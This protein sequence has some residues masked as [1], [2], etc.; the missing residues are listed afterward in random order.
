MAST[1]NGTSTGSGGLVSTGDDSGILNIQTNETTAMSIDASQ[2]VDFTNNIDAPNTFGF[3][4]R[5]INGQ[6]QV[7]QYGTSTSVSANASGYSCDRFRCDAPVGQGI[8]SAQVTASLSGFQNALQYTAGTASTNAV[9]NSEIIQFIE[10]YNVSDLQFGTANAQTITLSFWAKSSLTGT[11]GFILENGA[12]NRQYV[13]T[14]SLPTANTWTYIT[15]TI[16]GDTSG[17][18]LY[19]NGRGIG[20]R[21]DMGVGT[22][23]STAATNAWGASSAVGVTSTTKLTQT[24][25][26]TFTITGVQLEKGT[27]ATSFDFRDYGRELYLCQRYYFQSTFDN[28]N[29]PIST[30]AYWTTSTSIELIVIFPQEMRSAPSI[31]VPTVGSLY[32][33]QILTAWRQLS[34][35]SSNEVSNYGTKMSGNA[36]TNT[37]FATA[38]QGTVI[39]IRATGSINYSAEL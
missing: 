5:I 16:V 15:K 4:N 7:A 33:L 31:S 29:A 36:A 34:S 6:M 19:T 39:G 11:F 38:G 23:N 37:A 12:S 10:G 25:G 30:S 28:N 8:T 13:T 9:D 26:A 20:I 32:A 24:T 2:S 1:I 3:K 17:T 14:Y 35:I 27:Q 22:T 18:W 21:W